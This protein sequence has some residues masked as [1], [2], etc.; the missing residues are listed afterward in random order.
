MEEFL[1]NNWLSLAIVCVQ[2]VW[3]WILWSLRKQFVSLEEHEKSRM[4]H[5][6][7]MGTL[8]SGA[9]V[10]SHR[11]DIVEHDINSLP[12][13][14]GISEL[15]VSLERLR[16]EMMGVRAEMSGQRDSMKAIERQLALLMENELR[17]SRDGI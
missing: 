14:Q 1:Q 10:L 5:G 16:G 9:S 4:Q 3:G 13:A 15:T 12:T 8:E 2:A 17:G 6:E 11:L 7:R